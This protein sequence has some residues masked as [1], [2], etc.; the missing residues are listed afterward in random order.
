[1]MLSGGYNTSA[2]ELVLKF[3]LSEEQFKQ[4]C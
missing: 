1:M 4:D 2:T 3:Q